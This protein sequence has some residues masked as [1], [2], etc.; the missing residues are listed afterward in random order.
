MLNGSSQ[1]PLKLLLILMFNIMKQKSEFSVIGR[2]MATVA[3]FDRVYRTL[4]QQVILRG[5][6]KSTFENYIHRIAQ[7]SL[8]FNRL[9]EEI[10]ADDLNEFLASLAVSA[11][12]PSRSAF[13]HSVY[14]LRYYYRYVGLP[15]RAIQ[16]PSLKK[17]AKLPTIFNKSELRLLFKAPALLKHRVL[18]MLIYSAGLRSSEVINLKISDVDFERRSIHIRRSKFS[19]VLTGSKSNP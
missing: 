6:A 11:V 18:L 13:K 19:Q 9:P 3:G 1:L 5:Q 7:V 2:A 10:S 8:H 12:S 16:L 14:G 17:A 4:E 15:D